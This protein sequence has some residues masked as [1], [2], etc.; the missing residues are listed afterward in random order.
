MCLDLPVNA[1]NADMVMGDSMKRS[2]F[3]QQLSGFGVNLGPMVL[4]AA[5]R[6]TMRDIPDAKT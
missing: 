5:I 3:G 2:G 1:V 6:Y 4:L